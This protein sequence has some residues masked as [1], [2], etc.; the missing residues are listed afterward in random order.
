MKPMSDAQ[1][2]VGEI[3]ARVLA[4]ARERDWEQFH[5]PKNLSMALAAEAGE[6]ME[7]FL[8][9]E[10]KDSAAP[11]ADAKKREQIEDEIADVVIYALEFA[12]IGG[13]DLAKAIEAKLAKNAAKYPVE[14]ARG[15]AKKYTEL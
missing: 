9:T 4:F 5:S 3:R 11:L 8:W 13:I 15:S 2:T 12:N 6:L 14:K 10:A 1:T 7:H